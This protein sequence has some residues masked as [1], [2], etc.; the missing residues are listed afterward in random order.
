M[1]RIIDLRAAPALWSAALALNAAHETET[2][3]L[4]APAF[5]A[6]LDLCLAAPAIPDDGNGV[7][8]FL[9][10]L[11]EGADYAS[12]NYRW[13]AHRL[14][15]FAYVDRVIVAP[16][17]RGRGLGRQLYGAAT[18]AARVAGLAWLACEVNLVPPNP[19]SDAFH[20]ALG[21]QPIGTAHLADRGKTMRY[22]A[23]PLELAP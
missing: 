6:L 1:S 11:P 5:A 22:L 3:P 18:E 4:D 16:A 8:A 23:L 21:F 9:L 12:P 19:V 7:V 20:A 15:A 10:C 13:V 17:A 2:G 14:R